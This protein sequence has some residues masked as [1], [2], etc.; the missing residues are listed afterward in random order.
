MQ[1]VRRELEIHCSLQLSYGRFISKTICTESYHGSTQRFR[2][3]KR[4]VVHADEKFDCV[5]GTRI[6]D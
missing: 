1:L 4:L 3:L 2:R 6:G 5:S